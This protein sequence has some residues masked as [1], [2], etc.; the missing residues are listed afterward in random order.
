[1]KITLE[2]TQDQAERG[3]PFHKV[4]IEHPHDDLSLDETIQLV[5]AVLAAYGFTQQ[6][7]N[8][9]WSAVAEERVPADAASNGQ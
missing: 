6:C 3:H 2:P 5:G 9:Y 7:V 4:I 1:M 8:E